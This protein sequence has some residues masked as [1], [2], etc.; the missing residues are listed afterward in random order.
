M[1]GQVSTLIL[2]VTLVARPPVS[3]MCGDHT[4]G[5]AASATHRLALPSIE[6]DFSGAIR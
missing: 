3:V 5:R 4:G 1:K 2:G 6:G